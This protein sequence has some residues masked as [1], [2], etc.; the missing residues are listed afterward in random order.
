MERKTELGHPFREVGQHP[1]CIRL[2]FEAHYEVVSVAHD[3][4]AALCLLTP[5]MDP[6]I[7]NIM[8]GAVT[9]GGPSP[10]GM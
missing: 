6:E 10:E 2:A 8:Q 5:T 3:R 4:Y 9:V 7:E 1:P